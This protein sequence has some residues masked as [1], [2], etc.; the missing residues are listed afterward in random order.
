MT[1]RSDSRHKNIPYIWPP[2]GHTHFT[3][4]GLI[5]WNLIFNLRRM[6]SLLSKHLIVTQYCFKMEFYQK[7]EKKVYHWSQWKILYSA[8][9]F[10]KISKSIQNFWILF[11]GNERAKKGLF[12][13]Q[14]TLSKKKFK[15]QVKIWK[16]YCLIHWSMYKGHIEAISK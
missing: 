15:F 7:N 8:Y 12:L 9:I 2:V 10:Y 13:T 5:T 1:Y 11:F 16:K 14:Y 4:I 6:L 3:Y